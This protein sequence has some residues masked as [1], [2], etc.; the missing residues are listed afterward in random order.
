LGGTNLA[1]SVLCGRKRII[2][3]RLQ[4]FEYTPM[5]EKMLNK[6]RT[7]LIVAWILGLGAM[8]SLYFVGNPFGVYDDIVIIAGLMFYSLSS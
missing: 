7:K 6:S 2:P 8:F 5:T 1:L 4:R 3:N